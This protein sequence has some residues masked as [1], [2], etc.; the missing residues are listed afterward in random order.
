MELLESL[1]EKLNNATTKVELK[2]EERNLKIK[3]KK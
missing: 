2:K 3:E 1:Q